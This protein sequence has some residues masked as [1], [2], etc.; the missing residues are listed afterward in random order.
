MKQSNVHKYILKISKGNK[1]EEK[2]LIRIFIADMNKQVGCLEKGMEENDW[3]SIKIA[4]CCVKSCFIF[5]GE[6]KPLL[7]SDKIF[8]RVKRNHKNIAKKHIVEL[9]RICIKEVGYFERL[10]KKHS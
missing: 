10:Q 6:S 5:S 3:K 8:N 9:N 7:L 2:E 4:L 1:K